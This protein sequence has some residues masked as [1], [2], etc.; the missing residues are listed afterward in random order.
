MESG[1]LL[2]E[3]CGYIINDTIE[4]IIHG[5]R[6]FIDKQEQHNFLNEIRN[7]KYRTTHMLEM[8][9]KNTQVVININ[10]AQYS[11]MTDGYGHF[12]I[13]TIQKITEIKTS[14]TFNILLNTYIQ[15]KINVLVMDAN[16]DIIVSDIDDTIKITE[17]LDKSRL[18]RN[19]L[20]RDFQPVTN[21][22]N[23]Y[24]KVADK[25]N[26]CYVTGAPYQ[27]YIPVT[28]F[29]KQFNFP[30]YQ[31]SAFKKV[32]IFDIF[33][34]FNFLDNTRSYK[35][36]IIENLI[37]TTKTNFILIGDNTEFDEYVYNDIAVKYPDRINKI[38]IR[39]VS[40]NDIKYKFDKRIIEKLNIF[41]NGN[42]IMI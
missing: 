2:F 10:G 12:Y 24:N 4:F 25:Y 20:Y 21:M 3:S 42:D 22:S 36:A 14:Y 6:F 9:I 40:G 15:D 32:N 33:S 27:V 16:K 41:I 31:S 7:F 1:F 28:E 8:G 5:W 13:N 17:V 29:L 38:F 34:I 19:I 23:A 37:K 30:Q 11:A 18:L 39:Q 35:Y 26:F